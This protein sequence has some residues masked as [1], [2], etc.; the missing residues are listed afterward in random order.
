MSESWFSR[1]VSKMY[2]GNDRRTAQVPAARPYGDDAINVLT[3]ALQWD[4]FIELCAEELQQSP[5]VMLIIDLDAVSES[6][7]DSPTEIV[8]LLAQ[9]VRQAI[10]GDD[11]LAHVRQNRFAVLLR[12]APQELAHTISERIQESV[13]NTLFLTQSGIIPVGITI[14]GAQFDQFNA[15]DVVD[16]ATLY[17]NSAKSSGTPILVQ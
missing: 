16:K 5:G 14:G 7:A 2:S 3:S 8:P 13:K 6:A 17:Y 12:G 15:Q 11:L 4:R 9:A 1:L 10:R